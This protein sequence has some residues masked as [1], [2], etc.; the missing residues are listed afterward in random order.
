VKAIGR[1]LNV[2]YVLEGSVQRGGNRLR[3][4]VQLV[5]AQNGKH[6]WAERFDKPVADLFDMQDEIV[7]RLATQLGTVLIASEA[8]RAEGTPNPDAFDLYLQG[9]AWL[10]KDPRPVNVAQLRAFFGR[11][12]AIEPDN[13]DALIGSAGAD[14]WEAIN[15]EN[16][17]RAARFASAEA[18][19]LKALSTAPDNA[20]AHMWL[21]FV[22][23]NSNR[24][25]QGI[26]D[27]ERALA[28]NRNLPRALV[29]MGLAKLNVGR[30]EETEGYLQEA[31]NLS[32]R[33]PL[34]FNWMFIDGMAKIHLGAY[35][36]AAKRLSQS[37]GANPNFPAAHVLLATALSQLG[38]VEEARAQA[39]VGLVLDP[40][41]TI[42][43][44][45][46]RAVSDNPIFLKQCENTYEG[47]RKAGVREE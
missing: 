42:R 13:V 36:E 8:R 12:L 11:A 30:A 18:S 45:R 14:F 24:A 26:A 7:A 31:L 43:R 33:D 5:D 16:P 25:A 40:T 44:F 15:S 23:I 22:R 28:L 19:L 35:E 20:M 27:A 4:N 6:L 34:V 2:R 1:E 32:P 46:D 39:R 21:S 38:R 41:F 10:D 9:M 37:V 3:V 47:M 29:A 17:E